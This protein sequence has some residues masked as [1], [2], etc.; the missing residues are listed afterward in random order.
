MRPSSTACS[1]PGINMPPAATQR[2]SG[3]PPCCELRRPPCDRFRRVGRDPRAPRASMS[4]GSSG[5]V[6]Q[7]WRAGHA[8]GRLRAPPS[9]GML[10]RR[11]N[12]RKEGAGR[13]MRGRR[14][15]GRGRDG[16]GGELSGDPQYNKKHEQNTTT[17]TRNNKKQTKQT[18]GRRDPSHKKTNTNRNK[19]KQNKLTKLNNTKKGEKRPRHGE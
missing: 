19:T 6:V 8:V 4:E 9:C 2:R 15:E 17:Q 11:E 5:G 1:Q 13:G 18:R 10:Q 16:K 3:S 7:V 12:K 14:G